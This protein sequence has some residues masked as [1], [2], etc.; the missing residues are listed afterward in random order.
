MS[1]FNTMFQSTETNMILDDLMGPKTQ[2]LITHDFFDPSNFIKNDIENN[3][4]CS[5]PEYN[6]SLPDIF[7]WGQA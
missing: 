3:K 7:Q 5:L 1:G 2:D 6:D 4:F